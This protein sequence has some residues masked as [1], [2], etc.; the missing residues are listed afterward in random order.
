MPT[1]ILSMNLENNSKINTECN[2]YDNFNEFDKNTVYS[3]VNKDDLT[4]SSVETR[5]TNMNIDKNIILWGE[6]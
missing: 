3:R 5:L 1:N 4:F 6:I 2:I